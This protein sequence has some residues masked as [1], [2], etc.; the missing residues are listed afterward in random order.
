[1]SYKHLKKYNRI[2]VV[3]S[4]A[5][6]VVI[7]NNMSYLM[8]QS[9]R[10]VNSVGKIMPIDAAPLDKQII[11][12]MSPEPRS[13][14]SS[15]NDYD[16]EDTIIPFEPL[17][18]RDP[19][20]HPEPA[21]ASSYEASEDGKTWTFHLRP[22]ARWSDG[23][24]VT[25]HDFVYSFRRMVDPEEANPY[26]FFYYD[27]KN[28]QAIN[29]GD[30]KDL[31]Q[32]GVRAIDELTLV[33]ET[34]K[35]APYLPFIVS[36]GNAFPV[37]QWQVEKYGIKWTSLENIVS[38]SGFKLA[39][40][41]TGSHMTFTPDPMY[42]GPHKPYLEKVIHPFRDA[43]ASTILAYENNEVDVE[44]LDVTDLARIQNDPNL[45]PDLTRV[46][47]R[48]SWYL[49]FK[50][51]APPFNDVRV[52]EAFSRAVDRD[53]ICDILLGKTAVPAY[54]M[55]PPEFPE[56]NGPALKSYQ[57]YDPER[58]KALMKDAGYP[59]GRKFPR[60]E[61]WLRAPNPTIKRV[62]EAIMAML[63]ENLGVDVTIR[64]ADRTMYMSNLYN[65]RMNL[66]LIVFYADYLD[67]R[68]MLDMIWHS[69]P[70][71]YGRS[72][73]SRAEFDGLVEQAAAELDP[74]TRRELYQQ[75]EE[76]MVSD[77]AAGFLFH[78]VNLELRKP[79]LRGTPQNPDGTKGV[80]DY[81]RIYIG[82]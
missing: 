19:N 54:S 58:A 34:E 37:P 49:F 9:S 72:D 35:A 51:E 2:L 57:S 21:S 31:S 75:A 33:I 16:T 23:R 73:W 14:D 76:K 66:G 79:W 74:D 60:Q 41:I 10:L 6:L 22:G 8:A 71:G 30:I 62:A 36:F 44:R 69:Q 59:K 27:F 28:A 7:F 81:T 38:N 61:L 48:A 70:Q 20:W 18:R 67:P 55:I 45:A 77:Y 42:N 82:K 52:R 39:E 17:L 13:L 11:R 15:I 40:W 68:N 12:Y 32:L 64:S 50:T 56:Y 53:V 47:A 4:C 43:S 80:L 1:M 3:I 24:P 65:W 46:P 5:G 29:R 26:G 25:A 78:P 63:N